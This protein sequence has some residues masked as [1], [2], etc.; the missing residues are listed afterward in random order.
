MSGIEDLT[1]GSILGRYQLVL[2]VAAGGM[3]EVWAARLYGSRGFQKLVAVKTLLPELSQD[4][5]FEQM[6]LDEASLAARIKHPNVVEVMDLGEEEQIL[7]QIM[8]WVEGASLWAIMRAAAKR[9][10]KVLPMLV[11]A[12][13]VHQIAAG[14]HAAHELRDGD[15]NPLGLVHRD[16]S[17]QNI[18]ITPQ[19]VAKIV[20]FGVARFSG[21]KSMATQ[22]G[23]IRGKVPYMAPEVILGQ[24]IDRRADLF[25]LGLMLYQLLSGTHPFLGDSDAITL[26]RISDQQ[27]AAPLIQRVP[28]VSPALSALVD[29]AMRKNPAERIPTGS[30]FMRE[31]ERA[32]PGAGSAS[33]RDEVAAFCMGLGSEYF[34][35]RVRELRE[36]LLRLDDPTLQ[37]RLSGAPPSRL[38]IAPVDGIGSHPVLKLGSHPSIPGLL[39]TP[40]GVARADEHD[41]TSEASINVAPASG[42][43]RRAWMA[44]GGVAAVA[45]GIATAFALGGSKPAPVA[46]APR[47]SASTVATAPAPIAPV[48]ASATASVDPTPPA[49]ASAAPS[50]LAAPAPFGSARVRKPGKPPGSTGTKAPS[51]EFKPGG[52]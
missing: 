50:A 13:I 31:L 35:A 16:I 48:T 32:V 29:H 15:G 27:P 9:K 19:G 12:S 28:E 38:S 4:P 37:E 30:A 17:P 25:A 11:V 41:A 43:G 39:S 42:R 45:G 49:S 46:A 36:A 14:L 52:I 44:A 21:R 47:E 6:F 7:Y 24:P 20:D 1:A 33:A 22:V 2:R 26:A 51:G 10:H 23:E 18:L 40:S 8:E 5:N 34:P 3:G